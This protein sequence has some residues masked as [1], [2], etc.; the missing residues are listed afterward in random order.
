MVKNKKKYA[1]TT[2]PRAKTY[3]DMMDKSLSAFSQNV[4]FKFEL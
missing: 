3:A 1:I 4:S 2:L